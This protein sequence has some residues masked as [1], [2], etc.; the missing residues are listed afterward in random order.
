[1]KAYK[2]THIVK[3]DPKLIPSDGE[4]AVAVL[5][6]LPTFELAEKEITKRGKLN[7]T[8]WQTPEDGIWKM[9]ITDNQWT[10]CLIIEEVEVDEVYYTRHWKMMGL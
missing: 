10:L 1:M 2:M 8:E 7:L 9:P 6:I 4:F 3:R 5:G